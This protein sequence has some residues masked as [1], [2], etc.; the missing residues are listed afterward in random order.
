MASQKNLRDLSDLAGPGS[1]VISCFDH[2]YSKTALSSH[3]SSERSLFPP[4]GI[5]K[6]LKTSD[7]KQCATGLNSSVVSFTNNKGEVEFKV[8]DKTIESKN[9]SNPQ[10]PSPVSDISSPNGRGRGRI[11]INTKSSREIDEFVALS[12]IS[13]V[14]SSNSSTCL[15]ESPSH[16]ESSPL[17]ESQCGKLHKCPYCKSTFRIRGYLTRHMKKHSKRKAYMCP[18]YSQNSA[19][20]CHATGGFS[21]RDTYKTHLK[22]RHFRYPPGVKSGDRTGMMGWCSICGEKFVNNEIWVERHIERGMCPG[23]PSD[24]IKSLKIGKKKTGKHS[25]LLDAV[26]DEKFY[27]NGGYN[28]MTLSS[29][30]S[31][32]SMSPAQ[33]SISFSAPAA[34]TTR[35]PGSLSSVSSISSSPIPSLAF[36]WAQHK[37][38]QQRQQF[39]GVERV[40]LLPRTSLA[41]TPALSDDQKSTFHDAKSNDSSSSGDDYEEEDYPSLDAECSPYTYISYPPYYY[42]NV[43][44]SRN[45]PQQQLAI[46]SEGNPAGFFENST[47]PGDY[48]DEYG[49]L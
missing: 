17:L 28:H 12:P 43:N 23:L 48:Y 9:K 45:H 14:K 15:S 22:A 32:N 10:Q 7:L 4:Y 26:P 25:K 16:S 20:K 19:Q 11:C 31:L 36:A 5:L 30:S 39:Q 18:F 37:Q 1:F 40:G 6:T 41:E 21:R 42:K 2:G 8:I 44:D 24:Y 13:S 46:A 29:P 38:Q 47:V 3:V 33:Q 35:T 34:T 27:H 49:Q